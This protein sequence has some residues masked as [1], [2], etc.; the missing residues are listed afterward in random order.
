MSHSE[1]GQTVVLKDVAPLLT[2][3]CAI[4]PPAKG[5]Q[6][7]VALRACD[8]HL[9]C[10]L[11][12]PLVVGVLQSL[13]HVS[14]WL[15]CVAILVNGQCAQ[16]QLCARENAPQPSFLD[17][18][19]MQACLANARSCAHRL[20]AWRD[21]QCLR[22]DVEWLA[23]QRSKRGEPKV[24]CGLAAASVLRTHLQCAHTDHVTILCR[25]ERAAEW[26][27]WPC[28]SAVVLHDAAHTAGTHTPGGVHMADV[29][30][31][32]DADAVAAACRHLQ[33][34]QRARHVWLLRAL[35]SAP[36]F[37]QWPLYLSAHPGGVGHSMQ[38]WVAASWRWTRPL[39]WQPLDAQ[40]VVHAERWE[41]LLDM[42]WLPQ[43]LFVQHMHMHPECGT[44]CA[45]CAD[46]PVDTLLQP[47]GH[48]LCSEC[49]RACR[50]VAPSCPF[51]RTPLHMPMA[52]VFTTQWRWR[53]PQVAAWTLEPHTV[54]CVGKQPAYPA[55]T[56][57]MQARGWQLA[58]NVWELRHVVSHTA[59][60]HRW[61]IIGAPAWIE[62]VLHL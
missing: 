13:Q 12:S 27:A 56:A 33:C 38:D 23:A 26:L 42:Q 57:W 40:A 60:V 7:M 45:V 2:F 55:L 20:S 31:V 28:T 48:S 50:R 58:T 32:D 8:T 54:C 35:D 17:L 15:L 41:D 36:P 14:R 44:T 52:H 24:L 9:R 6:T 49:L 4:T 51:C 25:P 39:V 16:L 37:W 11:L 46:R 21:L 43:D 34:F 18:R 19:L 62:S 30:I 3:A 1:R 53:Q 59:G 47:C 5:E 29:V 22:V 10:H 61:V